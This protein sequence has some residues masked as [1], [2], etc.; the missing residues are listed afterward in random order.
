VSGGTG[1]IIEYFG[2]GVKTLSATGMGTIC[3]MG[4]EVRTP[5]SSSLV[6][7]LNNNHFEF[8]LVPRLRCFRTMSVK[9]NIFTPQNVEALPSSPIHSRFE[10]YLF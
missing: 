6:G 10:I 8:R 1:S 2:E 3:N 9:A 4:A 5:S 7:L